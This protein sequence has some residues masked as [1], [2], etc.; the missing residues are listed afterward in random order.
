MGNT[1]GDLEPAGQRAGGVT[2]GST[3]CR[4]GSGGGHLSSGRAAVAAGAPRRSEQAVLPRSPHGGNR[5]CRAAC[6]HHVGRNGDS[7]CTRR[8]RQ[9]AAGAKLKV[10]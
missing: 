6:A 1:G 10:F 3:Y 9:R 5:N 7:L 4:F 2:A 8:V